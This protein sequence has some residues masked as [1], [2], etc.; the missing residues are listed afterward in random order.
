MT[1][2]LARMFLDGQFLSWGLS[3]ED[4]LATSVRVLDEYIASVSR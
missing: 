3:E 4:A 1:Y 2:G